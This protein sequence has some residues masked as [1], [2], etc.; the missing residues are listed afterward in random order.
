MIIYTM[1]LLG[2]L[3]TRLAQNALTH[4]NKLIYLDKKAT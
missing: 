4:L 1:N 2:W 3:D